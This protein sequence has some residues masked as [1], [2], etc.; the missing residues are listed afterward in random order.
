MLAHQQTARLGLEQAHQSEQELKKHFRPSSEACSSRGH[1]WSACVT[2]EP[3][4]SLALLSSDSVGM[5]L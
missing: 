3:S 5:R 2:K 4:L 1:V